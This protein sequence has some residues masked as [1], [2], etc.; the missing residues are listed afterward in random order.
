MTGHQERQFYNQKYYNHNHNYMNHNHLGRHQQPTRFD[1]TYCCN[2]DKNFN[3]HGNVYYGKG[4]NID[5]HCNAYNAICKYCCNS[6]CTCNDNR[7]KDTHNN[8]HGY[9]GVDPTPQS[10]LMDGTITTPTPT[11]QLFKSWRRGGGGEGG[12]G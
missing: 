1:D 6:Y 11:P 9:L 12:E 3:S 7:T 4:H 2:V 5:V 8:V 10:D